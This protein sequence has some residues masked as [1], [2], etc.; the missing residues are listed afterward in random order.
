MTSQTAASLNV[1]PLWGDFGVDEGFRLY[2]RAYGGNRGIPFTLADVDHVQ[3]AVFHDEP[4][5]WADYADKI[6]LRRPSWVDA[7]AF[8]NQVQTSGNHVGLID[9][10]SDRESNASVVAIAVAYVLTVHGKFEVELTEFVVT[11]DRGLSVDV[12]LEADLKSGSW[13]GDA[14]ERDGSTS[15][16]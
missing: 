11:D 2:D 9:V 10:S 8:V 5:E 15:K 1:N 4:R 12:R 7:V 16:R 6:I 13:H 3:I 14:H